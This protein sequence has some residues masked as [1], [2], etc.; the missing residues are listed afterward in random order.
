MGSTSLLA[1]LLWIE[2]GA[3]I[4]AASA[5]LY[6][7]YRPLPA[8][9]T[10]PNICRLEDGGC[11]LLF[12]SKN[13]ALLGVPNSLLG[14]LF[15]TLLSTGLLAGWPDVILFAGS[16][17]ALFMSLYLAY[18]LVRD[19]L[20]CRICWIGHAVNAGIWI[21]LSARVLV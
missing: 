5:A 6:G 14:L 8:A 9:L 10:G 17:L 19:H 2:I 16:S 1:V 15:Y 12:R 20:E 18:V 21:V 11:G 4:T 3:G 13:A 7:R